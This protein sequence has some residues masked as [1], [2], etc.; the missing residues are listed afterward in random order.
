MA[1]LKHQGGQKQ[2]VF[3]DSATLTKINRKEGIV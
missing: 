3:T 1:V 2:G